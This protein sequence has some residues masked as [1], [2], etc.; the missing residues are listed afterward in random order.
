MRGS[1]SLYVRRGQDV[2]ASPQSCFPGRRWDGA[3][4]V[5]DDGPGWS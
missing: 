2:T 3:E 1:R 4:H 5:S